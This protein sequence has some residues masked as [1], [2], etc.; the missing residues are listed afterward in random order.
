VFSALILRCG[1]VKRRKDE[2]RQR[3]LGS[4]VTQRRLLLTR[5]LRILIWITRPI[6]DG[7]FVLNK[8]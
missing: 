3:Q 4:A 8:Q 5:G 6:Q 2:T 1:F 7:K